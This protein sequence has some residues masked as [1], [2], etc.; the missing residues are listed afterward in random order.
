[1]SDRRARGVDLAARIGNTLSTAAVTPTPPMVGVGTAGRAV[2]GSLIGLSIADAR[3]AVG[4]LGAETRVREV[5]G[6]G[7]AVGVVVAQRPVSGEAIVDGVVEVDVVRDPSAQVEVPDLRMVGLERGRVVA[8]ELGLTVRVTQEDVAAGSG[9]VSRDILRQEPVAGSFVPRGTEVVVTVAAV[10]AVVPV[11][12]GQRQDKAREVIAAAGF[13]TV[14]REQERESD[15]P[16]GSVLEQRP[17]AG[18][19][20]DVSTQFELVVSVGRPVRSRP[21]SAVTEPRT[22]RWE[23]QGHTLLVGDLAILDEH[24]RL[25]RE[26][27][28]LTRR[29]SNP[30]LIVRAALRAYERLRLDRPDDWMR[31]LREVRSS[32]DP[33]QN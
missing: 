19:R 11:V 27:G 31:H 12:V 14:P 8:G 24:Q 1:V 6:N 2:V 32:G 30:S 23:K 26:A 17:D 22:K 10:I 16:W 3:A 5:E 28:I 13:A 18:E 29:G 9:V 15:S 4:E 7:A 33:G 21:P 20:V 25:A